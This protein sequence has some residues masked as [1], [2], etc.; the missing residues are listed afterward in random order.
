MIY[1]YIYI[2]I[3]SYGKSN[4]LKNGLEK[5]KCQ[6]IFTILSLKFVKVIFKDKVNLYFLCRMFYFLFKKNQKVCKIKY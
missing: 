1:I 5:F 2:Y 4:D 6:N 3:I